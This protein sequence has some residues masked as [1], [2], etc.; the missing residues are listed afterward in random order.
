MA[1]EG[2]GRR[3]A[4]YNGLFWAVF[5]NPVHALSMLRDQLPNDITGLLG[6][7]DNYR[8]ATIVAQRYQLAA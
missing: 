3:L 6:S 4:Q 8:E 1:G 5:S 7:V 2:Q